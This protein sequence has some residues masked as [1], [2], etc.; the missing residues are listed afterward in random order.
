MKLYFLSKKSCWK[1]FLL[2][3]PL[4]FCIF[5]SNEKPADKQWKSWLFVKILY[6]ASSFRNHAHV[7]MYIEITMITDQTKIKN[8]KLEDWSVLIETAGHRCSSK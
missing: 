4:S 5:R 3:L 8:D 2:F 1:F 6:L 7:Y